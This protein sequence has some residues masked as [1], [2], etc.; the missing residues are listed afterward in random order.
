M[1]YSLNA[2]LCYLLSYERYN[3][4]FLQ[5]IQ[6][7]RD[8]DKRGIVNNQQQ[9]WAFRLDGVMNNTSQEQ[10]YQTIGANI[11]NSTLDG[12]NGTLHNCYLNHCL[13]DPL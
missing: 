1:N 13:C 3:R 7:H 2:R 5:T 12:Y 11:V 10:V 6:V 8:L 4:V 9:D